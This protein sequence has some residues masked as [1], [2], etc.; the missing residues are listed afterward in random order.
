MRKNKLA[1]EIIGSA[2][3]FLFSIYL[4]PLLEKMVSSSP[5]FQFQK[6]IT[7]LIPS[8]QDSILEFIQFIIYWVGFGYLTFK[9]EIDGLFDF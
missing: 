6:L 1:N 7:I 8:P 3:A 5:D 2:I 4:F 9:K